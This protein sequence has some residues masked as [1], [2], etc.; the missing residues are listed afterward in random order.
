MSILYKILFKCV[1]ER[2]K[3]YAKSHALQPEF[4]SARV[5]AREFGS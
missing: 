5:T 4:E 3:N 1:I 2:E